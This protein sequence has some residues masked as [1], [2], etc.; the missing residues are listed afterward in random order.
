MTEKPL[1]D[2]QPAT[3]SGSEKSG[4]KKFI[5]ETDLEET[6][7]SYIIYDLAKDNVGKY[8]WP[9]D[10]P[11]QAYMDNINAGG[12]CPT[13]PA[14][15]SIMFHLAVSSRF[16]V[17]VELGVWK[18]IGASPWLAAAAIINNGDYIGVDSNEEHL[19]TTQENLVR[20]DLASHTHLVHCNA[21][22][23]VLARNFKNQNDNEVYRDEEPKIGLLFIDDLHEAAHLEREI[24]HFLPQMQGGGL[25]CFHDIKDPYLLKTIVRRGGEVLVPPITGGGLGVIFT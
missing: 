18:G 13:E 6:P 10:A 4:S 22:D 15:S 20:F 2:E 9:N 12:K 21:L 16:R 7:G 3:Q 19:K 24:D 17:L 11:K 5:I 23:F 25:M 8:A 1:S 14:V